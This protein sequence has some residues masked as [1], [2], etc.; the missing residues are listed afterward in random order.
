[1]LPSDCLAAAGELMSAPNPRQIN[2]RKAISASYYAAFYALCRNTADCFIGASESDRS[3]RAWRQA[4]RSLDHGFAKRQ[5][6][7]QQVIVGFPPEIQLF[8][9][10]FVWLQEKRHAADYDPGI[11]FDL[12]GARNCLDR[13]TQAVAALAAASEKDRRD[14]AALV[15]LRD[16]P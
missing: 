8:A 4:F 11:T 15:T 1:M 12:E 3:G 14:F 5:C 16:R 10:Y 6:R 7:N 13:A 9:S 2:L